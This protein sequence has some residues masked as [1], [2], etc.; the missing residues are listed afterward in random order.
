MVKSG[1]KLSGFKFSAKVSSSGALSLLCCKTGVL[2]TVY[3]EYL[4]GSRNCSKAAC[5]VSL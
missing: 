4:S 2:L 5:C 1:A 3:F